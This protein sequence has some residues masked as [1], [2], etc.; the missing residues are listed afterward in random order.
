MLKVGP[1]IV[2]GAK[3]LGVGS[4]GP[5]STWFQRVYATNCTGVEIARTIAPSKAKAR[6]GMHV[7][8]GSRMAR[9]MANVEVGKSM[10]RWPWASFG[11]PG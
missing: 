4:P 8:Q 11:R 3:A 7:R 5:A 1:L 6:M 10:Q 9:R 2:P